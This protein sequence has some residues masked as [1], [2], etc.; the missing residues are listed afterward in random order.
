MKA[1]FK[2]CFFIFSFFF[3]ASCKQKEI[4][5]DTNPDALS[6]SLVNNPATASD[7]AAKKTSADI[8]FVADT[9]QFGSIKEGEKV[10]HAFSFSNKGNAPL[11]ISSAEG[12]CGCTIAEYPEKPIEPSKGG[13]IKVVFNS[14]GKSGHQE[15][16]VLVIS[17]TIPGT[18]ILYLIGE[19]VKK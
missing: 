17:N 12:S 5:K 8:V 11:L 3:L 1:K 6:S 10:E 14:K 15:K 16:N 4:A 9:F 19:V 7:N 2:L 18:K 13:A